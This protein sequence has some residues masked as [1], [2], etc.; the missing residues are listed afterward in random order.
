MKRNARSLIGFTM[1]ATDGE[2][3]K[4]KDLYF[5]DIT[6]TIRYLVVDTGTWLADRKVLIS[7][8]A[9]LTP[10]WDKE[11]LPVNLT[12]DQVK[13]SPDIDTEKP[14]SRQQEI[15]LYKH[16]PWSAYWGGGLTGM[17]PVSMYQV[18][19]NITGDIDDGESEGNP[20]LRSI[21]NLKG[22]KIQALNG[23]IGEVEDMI[24]DDAAWRINFLVVD[25]GKWLPGRKVLIS[26]SWITEIN[27]DTSSVVVDSTIEDIKHSPKYDPDQPVDD[28]YEA[29]LKDHYRGVSRTRF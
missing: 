3:G 21:E 26:P 12:Q 8:E 16:Y 23:H 6:W 9:V 13:N 15:K 19:D 29:I 20:H 5:D 22:Y 7:P 14:V 27:W 10:D 2:I 17:P 18:Y 25:T 1:G 4:V 11:I 28:A 24:L